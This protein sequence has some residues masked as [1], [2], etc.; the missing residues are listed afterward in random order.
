MKSTIP[1]RGGPILILSISEHLLGG[2]ILCAAC[3]FGYH[4][5]SS[6]QYGCKNCPSLSS[7]FALLSTIISLCRMYSIQKKNSSSFHLSAYIRQQRYKCCLYQ[8]N[9]LI[10]TE[11][12]VI[13]S[14]TF[15]SLSRIRLASA[16]F[17]VQYWVYFSGWSYQ[18]SRELYAYDSLKE[19]SRLDPA[20]GFLNIG[21]STKKKANC[22]QVVF[23]I[24]FTILESQRSRFI[25]KLRIFLFYIASLSS[26]G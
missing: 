9:T 6:V 15:P 16:L 10:N 17:S 3:S 19:M 5:T 1:K 11:Y 24:S 2:S 14:L 12:L 23:H 18:P 21:K 22:L 13:L 25:P 4:R 8:R 26:L 7:L 20:V